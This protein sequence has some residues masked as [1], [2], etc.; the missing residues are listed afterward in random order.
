VY[1]VQKLELKN[2]L[3]Y[4]SVALFHEGKTAVISDVIVDTGSA[5]TIISTDSIEQMELQ[6]TDDDTLVKTYGYGGSE[7]YSVRKKI[8]K[9][10]CGEIL[11]ENMMIDFGDVD[12]VDR[13]N[14]LLGLDFL[15]AAGVN[16]DLVNLTI[17]K[18]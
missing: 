11:I 10:V 13:V 3:L 9:I 7:S 4:T 15:M 17:Y 8:D 16:I 18:K 1:N 6:F 2:G 14:G 12:P 5:H